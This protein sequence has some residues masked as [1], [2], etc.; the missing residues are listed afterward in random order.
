[1][2]FLICQTFLLPNPKLFEKNIF[3]ATDYVTIDCAMGND[4]ARDFAMNIAENVAIGT[5]ALNAITTEDNKAMRTEAM[6]HAG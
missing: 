4:R 3:H 5:N 2:F 6:Y 1:M